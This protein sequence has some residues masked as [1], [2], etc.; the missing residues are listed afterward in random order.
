MPT[1]TVIYYIDSKA[2][3]GFVLLLILLNHCWKNALDESSVAMHHF[4]YVISSAA[5][6][7]ILVVAFGGVTLLLH[8]EVTM[9]ITAKYC[10]RFNFSLRSHSTKMLDSRNIFLFQS[11]VMSLHFFLSL[12]P[13]IAPMLPLTTVEIL[14]RQ[15]ALVCNVH[16]EPHLSLQQ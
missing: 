8:D 5:I 11:L 15:Q 3:N 6:I 1:H 14:S 16:P 13:L 10:S 9:S 4:S 2:K 7:Y 12:T